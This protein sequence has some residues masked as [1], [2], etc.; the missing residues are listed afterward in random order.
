MKALNSVHLFR[1][2]RPRYDPLKI[3][4]PDYAYVLPHADKLLGLSLL[5]AFI[6]SGQSPQVLVANHKHGRMLRN[7]IVHLASS[8]CS[9]FGCFTAMNR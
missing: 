2:A 7:S 1:R 4:F 8:P 5:G 9:K 6:M 3:A